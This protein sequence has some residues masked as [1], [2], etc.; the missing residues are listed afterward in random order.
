MRR[1]LRKVRAISPV[2]AEIIIVAIAIAIS[3]AVAGWLM[4]LWGGYARTEQLQIISTQSTVNPDGTFTIVVRNTGDINSKIIAVK[5][6]GTPATITSIS[7]YTTTISDTTTTTITSTTI[8]ITSTIISAGSIITIAGKAGGGFAVG[9][10]VTIVIV[11]D[12]GKQFNGAV[13]VGA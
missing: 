3:I 4:G 12:S 9:Q 5:I 8:T 11:T 10:T 2:I 1:T 6:G 7:S 13:T